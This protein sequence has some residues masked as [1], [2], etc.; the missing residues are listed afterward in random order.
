MTDL[1]EALQ[2]A[3]LDCMPVARLAVRG[4]GGGPEVMPIVFARVGRTLFSPIDGKPKAHARLARLAQIAVSPDV[5]LVL[6][7]YDDDWNSLWWLRLA[8]R[9][10]AVHPDHADWDLAVAALLAKYPQYQITPLFKDEPVM[11]A[12]AY[13]RVRWWAAGG[14]TA[15]EDW[16]NQLAR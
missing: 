11:I 12:M 9:A 13:A 16:I 1:P 7:H 5:G 6:D 15:M 2:F 4:E 8:A 14:M 3:L 10:V